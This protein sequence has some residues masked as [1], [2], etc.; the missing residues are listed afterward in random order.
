MEKTNFQQIK[1]PDQ[2]IN[3][4]KKNYN[5]PN[6]IISN[7]LILYSV[8]RR[9]L[10]ILQPCTK[11]KL[12]NSLKTLLEL[13]NLL[14]DEKIDKAIENLIENS[15]IVELKKSEFETDFLTER[16]VMASPALVELED[17]IIL[18]GHEN[19]NF[20]KTDNELNSKVSINSDGRRIIYPD[21][22]YNLMKISN[23]LVGKYGFVKLNNSD[24]IKQPNKKKLDIKFWKKKLDSGQSSFPLINDSQSEYTYIAQQDDVK[25][26][27][28]RLLK[29][30]D[31]LN[32][33]FIVRKKKIY[34]SFSH[35]YKFILCRFKLGNIT[36]FYDFTNDVTPKNSNRDFAWF[37]QIQIDKENA[38]NQRFDVIS[39]EI[40]FF[41][42]L[43]SWVK[44][45]LRV[46]GI[47]V[48][49][50][51]KGLFSF[52]FDNSKINI[53]ISYLEKLGLKK[54]D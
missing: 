39:N 25:Y 26:Y 48:S 1:D 50:K 18:V 35:N 12:L 17:S 51:S 7:E 6:N 41:S 19:N 13:T 2:L 53:V 43:P 30:F 34:S 27:N 46:H 29:D 33:D 40:I 11:I 15:D 54:S 24:W 14:I 49:D 22:T 3:I 28:K 38:N 8:I 52:K 4:L 5:I 10:Y 23:E 42:P 44:R 47:E 16:L 37:V 21:E 45:Y 20:Y 32:G 31:S 9:N 36:N